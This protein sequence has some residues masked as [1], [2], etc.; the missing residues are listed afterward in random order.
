M[1]II[2]IIHVHFIGATNRT[3]K[4]RNFLVK[5][6]LRIA[7]CQIYVLCCTIFDGKNVSGFVRRLNTCEICANK[8]VPPVHTHTHTPAE[9]ISSVDTMLNSSDFKQMMHTQSQKGEIHVYVHRY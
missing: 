9:Q 8:A 3:K 5:S 1:Y 7:M 2:I 4:F 6:I